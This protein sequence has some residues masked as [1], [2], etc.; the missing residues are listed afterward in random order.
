MII[1]HKHKFIFVKT[2]KTAGTSVE[3]SLSRYCGAGDVLSPIS[4]SDEPLRG[5]LGCRPR[6]Y[7]SSKDGEGYGSDFLWSIASRI[8]SIR[9]ETVPYRY[10][11][12]WSNWEAAR[13]I[14]AEG[15]YYNHM[16]A[17]KIE[18]L[19]GSDVWNSYFKFCVER[20][21]VDKTLSHFHY[22]SKHASLDEYL[23]DGEY[24]SDFYKYSMDDRICVDRILDFSNLNSELGEVC[25]SLGIDFDG[26]IPRAKGGYRPRKDASSKTISRQQ[27][28]RIRSAFIKEYE[29]LPFLT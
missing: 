16:R 11:K 21:P 7:L 28:E 3:I 18:A 12:R 8:E 15:G 4:L 2:R 29:S 22:L 9:P 14:R 1:S 23:D 10:R 19:C 24:C 13:V 26:W 17:S 25:Q 6:H 5:V 27:R 20:N